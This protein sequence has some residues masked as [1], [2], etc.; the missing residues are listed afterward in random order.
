VG[1]KT[2]KLKKMGTKL[3]RKSA[4]NKGGTTRKNEGT[5]IDHSN[6]GSLALY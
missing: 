6:R 2:Q 4:P 3:D 5:P 1:E